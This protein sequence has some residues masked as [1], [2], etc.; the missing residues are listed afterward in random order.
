VAALV[1]LIVFAIA[2]TFVSLQDK[3][4]A[5]EHEALAQARRISAVVDAEILAQLHLLEAL[6][7]SPALDEPVDIAGF[8]KQLRREQAAQP[9][10]LAGLLADPDGNLLV[11][12]QLP[13]PGK[14]VDMEGLRRVV[15]RRAAAIGTVVRGKTAVAVPLRAPVVQNGVVRFVVTA[16]I[17]SD[18]IRDRLLSA[19]LPS[20]WTG[21]VVDGSGLVAARTRGDSGLIGLPRRVRGSPPCRRPDIGSTACSIAC[22][23]SCRIS[24][25][26]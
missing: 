16:V 15:E 2:T 8:E 11:D 14:V 20:E 5:L 23:R 7:R 12:T 13:L 17:K 4:T 18:G 19:D 9:L 10:W 25:S 6:A 26:W 21:T 3:R 1:P 24:T 22:R